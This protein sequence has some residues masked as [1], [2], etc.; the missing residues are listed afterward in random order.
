MLSWIL[1]KEGEDLSLEEKIETLRKKFEQA[2]QGGG[3]KRIEKQHKSG[4][5]TARER[6]NLLLDPGSFEESGMFITNQSTGFG[7]KEDKFYGDG[8]ITGSGLI[9]GRRVYVF[10]QDFKQDLCRHG[11]GG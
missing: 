7:M 3:P 9:D 6:L 4:K 5:M 2:K 10:A 1:R 11:K 8:V